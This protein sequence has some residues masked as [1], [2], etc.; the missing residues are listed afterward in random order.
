MADQ[1]EELRVATL[2][3]LRILQRKKREKVETEENEDGEKDM[4]EGV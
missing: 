1:A 4:R 3:S 2:I